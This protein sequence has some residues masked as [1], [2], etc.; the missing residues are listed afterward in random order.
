MKMGK[1]QKLFVNSEWH[2][3]WII[4][5]SKKMM[6]MVELKEHLL[7]IGCGSGAVSSYFAE[8]YAA[9]ITGIDVDKEEIRKAQSRTNGLPIHFLQADATHLPFKDE[10]FDVVTCFD[11]LHHIKTWKNALK[12]IKRV[13]KPNGYLIYTDVC[14]SQLMAKMRELFDY[15]NKMTVADFTTFMEQNGI[16]LVHV[17]VS[18]YLIFDHCKAVLKK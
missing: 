12:E 10:T 11:V 18:H 16:F 1:L 2:E 3:K 9:T 4:T 5:L 17:V 8:T 15:G 7:D 6:E 14:Y 13:L